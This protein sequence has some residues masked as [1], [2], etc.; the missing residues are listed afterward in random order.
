MANN[1]LHH[2]KT[3]ANL[4]TEVK[5]ANFERRWSRFGRRGENA[6]AKGFKA[7]RRAYNKAHRKASQ[8]Q[9]SRYVQRAA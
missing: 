5:Y 9:L 2:D 8:L 4:N 7:I 3:L 6:G 1:T